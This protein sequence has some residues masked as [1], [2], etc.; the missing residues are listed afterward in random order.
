MRWKVDP[1]QLREL[2]FPEAL[3]REAEQRAESGLPVIEPDPDQV[4]RI[5]ALSSPRLPKPLPH[6]ERYW[7]RGRFR[8]QVLVAGFACLTGIL[9]LGLFTA[10]RNLRVQEQ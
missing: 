7:A 6:L 3:I 10:G 2:G 8:R 5:V 9:T 4:R 1:D